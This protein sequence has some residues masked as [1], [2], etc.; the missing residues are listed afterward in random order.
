MVVSKLVRSETE[1]D[2][3]DSM[4]PAGRANSLVA[5]LAIHNVDG[6]EQDDGGTDLHSWILRISM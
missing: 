3:D 1:A 5:G 2:G 4:L 6:E